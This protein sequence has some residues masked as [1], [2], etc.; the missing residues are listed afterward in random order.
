MIYR[1]F[2]DKKLSALGLGCKRLPVIDGQYGN[3]DKEATGKMVAYAMEKGINYYD[4]AWGYHM[5]MSEP[6]MGEILSEYPRESYYLATKF[7]GYDLSNMN[8]VEEIFAKQLEI[9]LFQCF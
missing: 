8:S 7:P 1:D 9:H 2:K 3:I 6:C 4:A 5:G